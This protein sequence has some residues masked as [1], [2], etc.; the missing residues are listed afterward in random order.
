MLK[1]R[2]LIDPMDLTVEELESIFLLADSIIE[3]PE[4]YAD[5]CKGKL[6]STCFY[7]PSTS[8]GT[9]HLGIDSI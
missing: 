3:K 8:P 2:H 7:E 1:G 4:D 6:L 9:G 5:V